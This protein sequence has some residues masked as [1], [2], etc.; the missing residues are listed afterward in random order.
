MKNISI[1]FILLFSFTLSAQ[2]VYF[3]HKKNKYILSRGRNLPVSKVKYEAY[4]PF[5]EGMAPVKLKG[6]WGYINKKGKTIIPFKF[7]DAYSFNTPYAIVKYDGQFLLIDENGDFR[8]EPFDS[9]Y[10]TNHYHIIKKEALF[11]IAD[12]LGKFIVQPKYQ[13]INHSF[14]GKI[15]IKVNGKWGY[16]TEAGEVFDEEPIIFV[17]PEQRPIYGAKCISIQDQ[18]EK[19]QCSTRSFLIGLYHNIKYPAEARKKGYQGTVVIEFLINEKGQLVDPVLVKDV[20]GGC[21]QEALRVLKTNLTAWAAPGYQDGKS[22]VTGF[23]MPV[24]FKLE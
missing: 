21:G 19:K 10:Y 4:H 17:S 16:W 18:E 7:D 3:K 22:V 9:I 23:L 6:K 24:S 2:E 13:N 20:K 15:P 1:I 12:S 14:R 8:S 11:G 5:K